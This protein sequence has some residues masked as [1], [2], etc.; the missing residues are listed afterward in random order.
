MDLLRAQQETRMFRISILAAISAAAFTACKHAEEKKGFV[1]P[2]IA[3][4]ENALQ[5]ERTFEAPRS[6]VWRT[7]TNPK[8]I[9]QWWGPEH[10][11]GSYA[12][13]DLKVGG[14]FL[15]AMRAPDK[16][17]YWSTGS[18]LEI[19]PERKIVVTDSF[20]NKKGEVVDPETYGLPPDM[21]RE[22]LVTV[23]FEEIAPNQT[24][25]SIKQAGMPVSMMKDATSGWSSSLD[26]FAKVL[27]EQ[28]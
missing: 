27:A 9:K 17:D 13:N 4:K 12:K 18:Y 20:S 19:Q 25:V 16:K 10:F 5:L 6:L 15:Y 11:T 3:R 28:K 1:P 2:S 22:M 23:I 21:P 14:K 8:L 26:K 7:W 24:K